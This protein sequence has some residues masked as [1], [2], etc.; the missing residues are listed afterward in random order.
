MTIEDAAR[1]LEE[2][3]RQTPWF[4]AVGV[5]S[6]HGEPALFL[7]VKSLRGVDPTVRRDGWEGYHVEVRTMGT[8]RLMTTL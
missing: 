3:F 8:P 6:H 2:R 5:G 4:T 1:T 7:Y